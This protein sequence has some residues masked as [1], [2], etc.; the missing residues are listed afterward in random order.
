MAGFYCDLP[1]GIDERQLAGN[2]LYSQNS[3]EKI[4]YMISGGQGRIRGNKGGGLQ[5]TQQW[6]TVAI[7]TGEEPISTS[8]SQTG[9]S[10][11]TIEVYGAPFDNEEDAS[12]IHRQTA[13]NYGWLVMI[14]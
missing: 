11:R 1:L 8:T 6:R 10:T 13:I 3:L 9:V 14:I 5:H 4:V 7:A 12:D 2:S